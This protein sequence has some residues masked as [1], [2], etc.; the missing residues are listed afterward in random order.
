MGTTL[1]ARG[2]TAGACNPDPTRVGLYRIRCAPRQTPRPR[3]TSW[4]DPT[5]PCGIPPLDARTLPRWA[6]S[7]YI[8]VNHLARLPLRARPM[9]PRRSGIGYVGEVR[10]AGGR[11]R[12]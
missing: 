1:V 7:N 11:G 2:A 10:R 4:F 6:S 3:P 8:Y 12:D 5:T 9:R